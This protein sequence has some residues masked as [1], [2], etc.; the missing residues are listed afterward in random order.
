MR[1]IIFLLLFLLT[2]S[3]KALAFHIVGGEMELIYIGDYVYRLNLIQYFDRAQSSNPGPDLNAV[4]YFFRNSDDTQ[5]RTATLTMTDE[6]AVAYTNPECAIGS[7]QTSRVVY[8]AEITLEPE[9]FNEE[10]G[11]YVTWERC[12]RNTSISNIINPGS[13][14]MT[15]ALDFPPVVKNGQPFVNSSPQL[16]PPLS[17]YA[18]VDQLYYTNFAGED[19][20]EDSISYSLQLP[21][22]SSSQTPVPI[23]Q[24]KPFV[25]LQYAN[26]TD[27]NNIIPGKPSLSIT[28][29]GYLTVSPTNI[30]LYVFS[31]LVEE[32]RNG[33]KLG[34]LRRDFQMLVVDGC[35]PPTPPHA[36]VRLDG[37]T[38][39]YVEGTV[40]KYSTAE[41][42]CF[43]YLVVDNAGEN[44]SFQ[45]VGVNFDEEV[46][47]I[48]KIESSTTIN[49][50]GD[51]LRVEVCISDCPYKQDDLF[52]IDLIAS[53]NACPLPQRDT[54]RMT[55]DVQPPPNNNPFYDS[56]SSAST[57]FRSEP[58]GQVLALDE[59]L[60]GK[61]VDD[62]TLQIYFVADGFDPNEFGMSL[63]PETDELGEK[64]VKFQW[65]TSC[66]SS[67]FGDKNTFDLGIVLEDLDTCRFNNGDTLFYNL[68]VIIPENTLPTLSVPSNQFNRNIKANLIFEARATD[69]DGDPITL[70][71]MGD[72]FNLENVGAEFENQS[73]NG[74]VASTFAWDLSCENLNIG[75][76]QSYKILF[77]TEDQDTC[78]ESNQDTLEVTV[79]VIVP[80]NNKPVFEIENNYSLSINEEFTLDVIASDG[81]NSDLLTLDLLSVNSAPDSEGFSFEGNTGVGIV[82]STLTWTPECGVLGK[83]NEPA[84]YTVD[85]LVYDDNCPNIESQAHSVAF[86]VT[87]LVVDYGVFIPP[88]AFSPNG[89]GFNDTFTLT[90]LPNS[91]YNLP[92][93]NCADQFQSIIIFD[94]AGGKVFESRDREFIW[95]GEGTDSGVYYYQIDYLNNDYKGTLTIL[96]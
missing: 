25:E 80:A 43:E 44:V 1:K 68:E 30:G 53:D 90:N 38:D 76:S 14:G 51:T 91:S 27:I 71:A 72:G 73:G 47:D 19:P 84:I 74:T 92:P 95:S 89:D 18:C 54:V 2:A 48:F 33:E 3:I 50:D 64:S 7:L 41:E 52:I 65:N 59:L 15:Y 4:V 11:Y 85:F 12:C 5:I 21:Y 9:I 6:Q 63:I 87:E 37:E 26:G 96:R 20:D 83:N 94:R 61:D 60:V 62:D 79:N 31:V 16:F 75:S 77:A 10:E 57:L 24:P 81:D 29:D 39:L 23:P 82:S 49:D 36:E 69:D 22:N 70:T 8:S 56:P 35:E 17:D 67:P 13:Q 46:S 32:F 42:K 40:I 93:D 45:A 28:S 34:E 66:Q 58:E 86:E 78:H 88:N 55:F